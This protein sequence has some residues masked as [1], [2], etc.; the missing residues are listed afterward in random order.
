MKRTLSIA[1]IVM[2]CIAVVVGASLI[3]AGAEPGLQ[4]D[5][6]FFSNRDLAGAYAFQSTGT[7]SYPTETPFSAWNGPFAN[8]GRAWFNGHGQFKLQI[9]YNFNGQTIRSE[10][11]GTYIVERDGTFA[12]NYIFQEASMPPVSL[13]FDGVLANEGKEFRLLL[14]G[15]S[16]PGLTLP[17]GY[18][19]MVIVTSAT[20]Q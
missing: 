16:I 1:S 20:R 5:H 4:G 8:N 6:P 17:P 12:V 2:T 18:V 9:V 19:P 15:Q 3:M 7:V 13:S 10:S 11:E 14:T